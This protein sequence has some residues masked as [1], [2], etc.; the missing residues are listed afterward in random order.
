MWA[1]ATEFQTQDDIFKVIN[2]HVVD[3][4]LPVQQITK[5]QRSDYFPF[6]P[7]VESPGIAFYIA[8]GK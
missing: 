7:I 3:F 6:V 2:E 5:E 4:I 1:L 8:P